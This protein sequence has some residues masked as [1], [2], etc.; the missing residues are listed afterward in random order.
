MNLT[1]SNAE[2]IG[3]GG[4][5]PLFDEHTLDLDGWVELRAQDFFEIIEA[6]IGAFR[7]DFDV[8]VT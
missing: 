1:S 4:V 3:R 5:F 7:A 8:A 2:A 6:P